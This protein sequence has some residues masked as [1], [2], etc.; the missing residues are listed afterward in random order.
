MTA[1]CKGLVKHAPKLI[2]AF[3][4][5]SLAAAFIAAPALAAA[6]KQAL[7]TI[8][9]RVCVD[10]AAYVQEAC[11]QPGSEVR[12]RIVL[13]LPENL[14]ELDGLTYTVSDRPA[15]GISPDIETVDAR[16]TDKRGRSK[17]SMPV[18]VHR[19]GGSIAFSLGNVKAACKDL[20]FSDRVV[21]GYRA[22]V[23]QTADAGEHPNTA[24][25]TYDD[26]RGAKQTVDVMANVITPKRSSASSTLPK[27]GDQPHAWAAGAALVC[28]ACAALARIRR[29]S[30]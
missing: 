20:A 5:A 12:Y 14:E 11:A 8:G 3:V 19:T 16:V 22:T 29:E 18:R 26:G 13:T 27:T 21:I 1:A 25:L 17:G 23:S 6:G 30:G 7:P 28:A 9:K 15:R 4:L 24:H 10:G 2:G